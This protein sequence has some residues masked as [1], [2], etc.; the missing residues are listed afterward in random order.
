MRKETQPYSQYSLV[1]EMCETSAVIRNFDREAARPLSFSSDKILL[2]G[3]GSSRIFPA[4]RSA[5]LARYNGY[6]QSVVVEGALQAADYEL[7]GYHLFVASNSG[8]TAE[9]VQLL[10][11]LSEQSNSSA[12]RS[13]S[14]EAIAGIVG[15]AETPIARMSD[16]SYVL[17]CGKEDAVAASKSV[18]EQAL[19]YETLFRSAHGDEAI[20]LAALSEAFSEV[21]STPIDPDITGKLAAS[22]TIYFAGRNDGVAEELTLKTNEI[23]RLKSDYLEGTYAVHG[24]EEVMQPNEVVVV[25]EPFKEEEQKFREVLQE[26]VGMSVFAV[27]NRKTS[28]P[29]IRIPD[30]DDMNPYL[31][32]AAGWN[33]LVETG[34]RLGID[35]DKPVRARKV[36]NEYSSEPQR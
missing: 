6:R 23:T 14:P 22:P 16:R 25:V 7:G 4:K 20:D 9:G 8:K 1:K 5:A 29:T 28:F 24:I 21:L 13:S 33:L 11:R 34:I 30:L 32:L 19:V 31:Q 12:K 17:R 36:G 2:T 35:L 10:S 3:E 27:S 26:G 18:I 15:H